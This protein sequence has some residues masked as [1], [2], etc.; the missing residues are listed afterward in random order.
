MVSVNRL[1]GLISG[2]DT[3]SLVKSLVSSQSS[4]VNKMKQQQQLLEW[5]RADYRDL[6]SKVLDLRNSA[7]NMKLQG[8]YLTKSATSSQDGAVSVTGTSSANAGQYNIEV[9][10]LAKGASLTSGVIGA[11]D[12]LYANGESMTINGQTITFTG[13]TKAA[14]LVNLINAK[15]TDTG[16]KASYDTTMQRVFFSTM[17]TGTSAQIDIGGASVASK[18][19]LA[20]AAGTSQGLTTT[21][22][23]PF[24]AGGAPQNI[25]LKVGSKDYT[26][27]LSATDKVGDLLNKIN[28]DFGT[29]GITAQ[30][31]GGRIVL[32]NP[33]GQ[34]VSFTS[35]D[36]TMLAGLGL[37]AALDTAYNPTAVKTTGQNAKV[38][39]NGVEGSYESNT[40][41]ISGMTITAKTT[42][43]SPAT[44]TVNQDTDAVFKTIKDFVDKYNTLIDT[45]NTKVSES[46]D[47]DYQPLTDEQKEAMSEDDIKK[48]EEKA[49]VGLLSR[50]SILSS[51]LSSFRQ[52]FSEGMTGMSSTMNSLAQIGISSTLN[53][54]G[55]V[56]G[57]YLDKG[58]IY[59][60]EAKLKKA[61]A[62]N[63][64]E[65]MKLFTA[66]DGNSTTSSGDGLAVRLYDRADAI[67]TKITAKA[68]TA[69]SSSLKSYEI[70][71]SMSD[72]TTRI[73]R[74]EVRI[75]DMQDRYYTQFARME[76]YL[77][78]MNSQSS[79][80]SQQTG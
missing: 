33:S 40:F 6:N 72:L 22:A 26:Y 67:I 52:A 16:V 64:D 28:Q 9:S 54:N 35:G 11:N 63:P 34:A 48:W 17:K 10:S 55:V 73:S 59:I 36:A 56:Q 62:D 12:V 1:S 79:W 18:L 70:G 8:S 43:T 4:K 13:D 58:K 74:E 25:T 45:V 30:V 78:K 46:Y 44:L 3:D 65:V 71:K 75:A 51:G 39:F 19:K 15:S 31:D 42:T 24:G 7:F 68:G 60:D 20:S 14:D 38:K 61:I 47:R 77:S 29:T 27:S 37:D 23:I 76:S 53:T 57:T 5:K 66:N 80:L 50:D 69:A 32:N 41:S 49:K 21:S 2:M